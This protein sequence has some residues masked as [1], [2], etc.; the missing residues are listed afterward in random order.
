MKIWPINVKIPD[1]GICEV[2]E[3][4]NKETYKADKKGI[5]LAPREFG[6]VNLFQDN[7]FVAWC[8]VAFAK[9]RMLKPKFKLPKY[10]RDIPI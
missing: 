6:F 5:N 8:G 1:W 4:T 2:R 10:I 3:M 7:V 9:R